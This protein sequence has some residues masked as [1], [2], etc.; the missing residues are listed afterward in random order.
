MRAW[1]AGGRRRCTAPDHR[2][3]RTRGALSGHHFYRDW[4]KT[5][6]D[7]VAILHAEAGRN[8]YD[9]GLTDLVGELSTRS[10]EF[11]SRWAA[12][13]VRFHRTGAKRLHHPLLGDLDL[14]YE[15]MELTADA[16]QTLLVYTAEPATPTA[17]A[18]QPSQLDRP[19]KAS[20][21][22]TASDEATS[23]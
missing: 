1:G 10:E 21:T 4:E 17:D 12:H 9:R 15:A 16:G 20:A 18:L 11:R 3:R 2:G 22:T 6:D 5:A 23:T 19:T 13:N 14:T 7:I 8:P